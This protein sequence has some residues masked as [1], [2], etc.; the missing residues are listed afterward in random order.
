MREESVGLSDEELAH[1]ATARDFKIEPA[2]EQ[3]GMFGQDS[4]IVRVSHTNSKG[5]IERGLAYQSQLDKL[6]ET[7]N[8]RFS[9]S[10]L[11]LQAQDAGDKESLDQ[12]PLYGAG[13]LGE[14]LGPTKPSGVP[15]FLKSKPPSSQGSLFRG[16]SNK[17]PFMRRK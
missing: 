10:P 7:K 14:I 4:P 1:W 11:E 3:K 15:S 13:D 8:G 5:K 12:L 9:E 6:N 16:S 17:L 2:G